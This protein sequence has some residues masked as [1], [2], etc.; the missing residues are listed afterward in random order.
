MMRLPLLAA[1]LACLSAPAWAQAGGGAPHALAPGVEVQL[2]APAAPA[3]GGIDETALRHYARTGDVARLEAEIARLKAIDPNWQPP[4]DLFAPQATPSGVDETP[5]WALLADGKTAEARAAVAEQRRTTPAWTPSDKLTAELTRAET[6][7]R[8][9]TAS[10]AGHWQEVVDAV[11]ADPQVLGCARLDTMWRA[12]QAYGELKRT[13]RAFDLYRSVMSDCPNAADRRATLFKASP[14]LS[15]EQLRTL[16][17]LGTRPGE[18][19]PAT[20]NGDGNGASVREGLAELSAGRI[21]Q[22][23]SARNAAPSA[24][25]LEQAEAFVADRKS[26]DGALAIG[27]FY[28]N[29]RAYD[30]ARRWFA[31]SADWAPSDRAAEG[32]VLALAGLG[33]RDEA[34]ATAKPWLSKSP[35]VARAAESLRRGGGG[36]GSGGGDA[37]G[38]RAAA[39]LRQAVQV[40]DWGRCLEIVR[41]ERQAGRVTA[42]LVQQSGWCLLELKRT[43]E[44][45]L[46]FGEAAA[47]A[48]KGRG[49]DSA[50]IADEAR[51]G[52]MLARL[53][54]DGAAR[55]LKAL[56]GSGL[57]PSQKTD[58]QADAYA[59]LALQAYDEKRF[60]D[61]L[62]MLE[63]RRALAPETR[64]LT[65]MRGWSLYHT[66]R[67]GE[68]LAVFE[69][70]DRRLSTPETRE[71]V[72]VV[73]MSLYGAWD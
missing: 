19:A 11:Q 64:G 52:Q 55:V 37:P 16:A 41:A 43:T 29:R 59:K 72:D 62:R 63:A 27:W 22:R 5:I 3:P 24:A 28:Q 26:A 73:R 39:A 35:R 70:L 58:V 17:E 67:R 9:R 6:T 69:E 40:R 31:R 56:P 57:T 54:L 48:A 23:L 25:E 32:L 34:L 60:R 65:L 53:E 10:D 36:A 51:Y 68:A 47:L 14:Y 45:D 71:A 21:L 4:A 33:R 30:D 49:A 50:R 13:E 44:A 18:A 7:Q 2:D 42:A 20:A 61:A 8:V 46:A 38:A 15:E 1:T 12:A 66:E